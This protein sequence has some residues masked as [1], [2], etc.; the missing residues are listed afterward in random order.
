[1]GWKKLPWFRVEEPWSTLLAL[2]LIGEVKPF[3]LDVRSQNEKIVRRETKRL[4]ICGLE[5]L[6]MSTSWKILVEKKALWILVKKPGPV[7]TCLKEDLVDTCQ[8]P[9]PVDTCKRR[10]GGCL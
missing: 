5:Y 1:M 6:A 4:E 10:S 7:D 2:C 8:K 3:N 9:G